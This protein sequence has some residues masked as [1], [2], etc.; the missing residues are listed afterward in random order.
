MKHKTIR[1][2]I[3]ITSRGDKTE[4]CTLSYRQF[5]LC[6]FVVLMLACLVGWVSGFFAGMEMSQ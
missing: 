2:A 1:T 5:L 3:F 6:L 4:S